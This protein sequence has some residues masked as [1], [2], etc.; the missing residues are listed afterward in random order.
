MSEIHFSMPGGDSGTGTLG[1][2]GHS[3]LITPDIM[4]KIALALA[5][6]TSMISLGLAV[7]VGL[8]RAGTLTERV[9]SV[10]MSLAAVLW[11]HLSPMLWRIMHASH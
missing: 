6:F 2:S 9:W 10:A 4:Q 8:Q 3:S 11:V 1:V 5:L 7:C